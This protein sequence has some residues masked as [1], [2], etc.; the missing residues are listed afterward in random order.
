MREALQAAADAGTR[1]AILALGHNLDVEAPASPPPP[2]D[3]VLPDTRDAFEAG[4]QDGRP[5]GR[6]DPAL[7][8]NPLYRMG[9]IRGA[10][11]RDLRPPQIPEEFKPLVDLMAAHH[12]IRQK[13]I[14]YGQSET[15]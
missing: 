10:L 5:P 4:V 14:E 6:V 7:S 11:D 9:W 13:S 12:Q 2:P 15:R 1:E 8:S 3:L